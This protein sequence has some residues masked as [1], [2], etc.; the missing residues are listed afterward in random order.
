MLVKP[1]FWY[2]APAMIL[3][4]LLLGGADYMVHQPSFVV[5]ADKEIAFPF[6][7]TLPTDS[8]AQMTWCLYDLTS[9]TSLQKYLSDDT[10]F[11]DRGYV[12]SDLQNIDSHFTA[13]DSSR[14]QLR[15]EAALQFA[16]MARQFWHHFDGDKL[17][18]TS[19]YRTPDV[20]NYLFHSFCKKDQCATPGTSEHQAWLAIDLSVRSKSWLIKKVE[21][22]N[23]YYD[24]FVNNA[25]LYGF[26][27]TYQRWVEIDGKIIEWRHRRYM[28]TS[29]ATLLHDSQ[30]TF[31]EWMNTGA[32]QVWCP[33]FMDL[34]YK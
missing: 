29:L 7:V 32:N 30:Q 26:H 4:W 28:W 17:L 5:K 9:D 1:R 21:Q 23:T 14:Y 10:P 27:N 19:A 15:Q 18:I 8:T 20:Q 3:L 12:P 24:W 2:V 34:K 25:H 22:G 13:N 31:A 16:D 6:P 33:S 11:I